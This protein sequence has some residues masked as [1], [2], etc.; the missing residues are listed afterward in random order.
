MR[1]TPQK[2]SGA[3]TARKRSAEERERDLAVIAERILQGHEQAAIAKDLGLSQPQI[4]YD[5]RKIRARWAERASAAVEEHVH[6]QLAETRMIK[7]T[8]WESWRRSCNEKKRSATVARKS[9]GKETA[10]KRV[11]S[12][13]R[14]GNPAYLDLFM[15]AMEREARLLG[16][17]K[18]KHYVEGTVRTIVLR[19]NL[20]DDNE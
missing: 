5:M 15:K 2:K 10:E 9:G 17:D 1:R 8:A 11:L 20:E 14:D 13:E 18:Q 12:E 16:L 3:T 7:K 6:Q 4:S 19:T